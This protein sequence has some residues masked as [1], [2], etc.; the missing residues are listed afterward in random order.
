MPSTSPPLGVSAAFQ[1]RSVMEPDT[2]RTLPSASPT[3]TLP[4]CMLLAVSGL[5]VP[6]VP[7]VGLT[8][9][10]RKLSA[11]PFA[12]S[13]I[14]AVEP[15]A[16]TQHQNEAQEPEAPAVIETIPRP[17]AMPSGATIIDLFTQNSD[18]LWIESGKPNATWGEAKLTQA[19]ITVGDLCDHMANCGARDGAMA[20]AR[21]FGLPEA[22]LSINYGQI[23][24]AIKAASLANTERL[25][26][27]LATMD[28]K[29]DFRRERIAN[30]KLADLERM[31][32]NAPDTPV[33]FKHLFMWRHLLQR[34]GLWSA[35]ASIASSPAIARASASSRLT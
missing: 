19:A 29:D 16:G 7:R 30:G 31:Y 12:G 17:V 14:F 4:A 27:A 18:K 28:P 34:I 5:Q 13:G 11:F 8:C 26:V 10:V 20:I 25:T 6:L 21:T 22:L 15:E 9:G 33:T 24:N 35:S 32:G 2:A 1:V 23:V 3:S